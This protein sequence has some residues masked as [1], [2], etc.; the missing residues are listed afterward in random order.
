[1]M[2]RSFAVMLGL[3]AAAASQSTEVVTA[4]A[5]ARLDR[6]GDGRV[7][8]TEFPG[9]DAQFRDLGAGADGVVTLE[10]FRKSAFAR[11]IA[12]ARSRDGSEPRPRDDADRQLGARIEAALRL[13]TNRDGRVARSEWSGQETHFLELDLD[14]DGD[15]DRRDRAEAIRRAPATPDLDDLPA[16]RRELEPIEKLL[17][18]FDR[19]RDGS[20][21]EAELRDHRAAPAFAWADRDRDGL[22]STAELE[23]LATEIRNRV[24]ARNLGKARPTAYVVPLSTWDRDNDGRISTAEWKG[25]AYLVARIDRDRDAHLTRDEI[26]R[27]VRSVEGATFHE[28]FDLDDDGRVTLDEFAGPPSAFRRLDRNGD[29]IV[30]RAEG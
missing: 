8:R 28:R 11:R 29:G 9:S 1:M 2:L 18:K 26:D 23:R 5:F 4:E 16:F 21:A 14:G 24:R 7:V 3:A 17:D 19:N 15:I 25:P 13:D 22:L 6:N 12:A 30:S 20:L 27:Y 10:G